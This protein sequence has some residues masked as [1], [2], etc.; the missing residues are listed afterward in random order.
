MYIAPFDVLL[1]NSDTEEEYETFTVVQPDISVI[2][3]QNKLTDRGCKGAPDLL[4]EILSPS[5]AAKDLKVKPA[6]YKKHG[7]NW[8]S[9][10]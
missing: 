9:G 3:D 7:V 4:V 8:Y 5:T 1:V 10:P 6:L 2:C